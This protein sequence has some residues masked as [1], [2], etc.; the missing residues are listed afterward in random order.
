MMKISVEMFC[1][2]F[3]AQFINVVGIMFGR[4][5]TVLFCSFES[6]QHLTFL[7]GKKQGSFLTTAQ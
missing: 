2:L 1:L 5:F 7:E 4:K 6:L 3:I